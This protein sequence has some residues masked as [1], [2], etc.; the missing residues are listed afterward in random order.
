MAKFKEFLPPHP[1]AYWCSVFSHP[2]PQISGPYLLCQQCWHVF[3]FGW[4]TVA[5][6]RKSHSLEKIKPAPP[7][8]I[9]RGVRVAHRHS[10]WVEGKGSRKLW[11]L[12]VGW[13]QCLLHPPTCA[14]SGSAAP[15]QGE[16][17][18]TWKFLVS[19]ITSFLTLRADC[20]EWLLCIRMRSLLTL[21]ASCT[22]N[23]I[24]E[25]FFSMF[26]NNI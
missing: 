10:Q 22:Q 7:A 8:Y 5:F 24:I 19:C 20:V 18:S 21:C 13:W 15:Q 17:V 23:K 3:C 2:H 11:V 4:S 9:K 16:K 14:P 25:A 12:A 26:Q 1:S 6:V